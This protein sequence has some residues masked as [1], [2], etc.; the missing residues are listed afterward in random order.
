MRLT[1]DDK[2]TTYR[3]KKRL[4][5]AQKARK[6]WLEDEI[7]RLSAVLGVARRTG[8]WIETLEASLELEISCYYDELIS[9]MVVPV[10]AD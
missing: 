9:I 1:P 7:N 5:K 10:P 6:A 2:P 8:K 4:T 3:L